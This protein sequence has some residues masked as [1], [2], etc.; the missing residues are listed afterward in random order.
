MYIN[1]HSSLPLQ[2]PRGNTRMSW[3]EGF[4]LLMAFGKLHGHFDVPNP[5]PNADKMSNERRLYNWVMS[6][7]T[8]YKSYKA[9][10]KSGS[11][12]NERVVLL[13]K[14]GFVFRTE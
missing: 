3:D 2:T 10:R 14:N 8:M 5:G 13:I 4:E 7:H 11:L 6:L 12:N 1:L 9:G